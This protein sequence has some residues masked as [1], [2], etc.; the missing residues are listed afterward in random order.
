[1]GYGRK[2]GWY[3]DYIT[4]PITINIFSTTVIVI[5]AGILRPKS[6]SDIINN[7][8]PPLFTIITN[9]IS[10]LVNIAATHVT[11]LIS[12]NTIL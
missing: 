7:Y 2:I 11:L 4:P 3:G 9:Y 12:M 5:V 6:T 8:I 1:M 10:P